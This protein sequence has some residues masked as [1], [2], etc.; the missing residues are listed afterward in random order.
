MKVGQWV[1]D[2]LVLVVL[3]LQDPTGLMV[4]VGGN[5]LLMGLPYPFRD[6]LLPHPDSTQEL[7]PEPGP[8]SKDQSRMVDSGPW[9]RTSRSVG[10]FE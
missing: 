6:S 3:P 10:G 9:D 1:T 7:R 4:T 5:G 2:V 8:G